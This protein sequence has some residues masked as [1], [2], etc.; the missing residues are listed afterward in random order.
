[1][2]LGEIP[3]LFYMAMTMIAFAFVFINWNEKRLEK[4]RKNKKSKKK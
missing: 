2:K 3:P 1:M 4:L